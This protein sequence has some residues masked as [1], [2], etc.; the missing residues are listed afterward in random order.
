M[1]NDLKEYKEEFE[2]LYLAYYKF[3]YKWEVGHEEDFNPQK[4]EYP[5]TREDFKSVLYDEGHS[6]RVN[7]GY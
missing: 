6:I 7:H 4:M 3:V 5:Y 2:A 1:K